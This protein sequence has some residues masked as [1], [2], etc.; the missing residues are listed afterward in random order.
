MCCHAP[1]TATSATPAPLTPSPTTSAPSTPAPTTLAPTPARTLVPTTP[2]PQP[3]ATAPEMLFS[4]VIETADGAWE[5]VYNPDGTHVYLTGKETNSIVIFEVDPSGGRLTMVGESAMDNNSAAEAGALDGPT[6]VATSPDGRCLFVAAVGSSSLTSLRIGDG[7]IGGGEGTGSL[8][9][10]ARVS[11]TALADTWDVVVSLPSGDH[12]YVS[13]PACGCIMTF[14]VDLDTCGLTYR[15]SVTS[16]LLAPAG[17]SVSP[18]GSLLYATDSAMSGGALLLFGTDPDTGELELLQAITNGVAV[19]YE[20]GG[21]VSVAVSPSGKDV[22]VASNYPGA[23][24]HLC[25]DESSGELQ[26]VEWEDNATPTGLSMDGASMVT[27]NP[28]NSRVLVASTTNNTL[29]VLDN[30]NDD[31][32][33][34]GCAI[35]ELQDTIQ[36]G[37]D[38]DITGLADARSIS[39]SPDGGTALV[40]SS[41]TG[42][43]AVFR[44]PALMETPAPTSDGESM[45][46]PSSEEWYEEHAG[47]LAMGAALTAVAAGGLVSVLIANSGCACC[48]V[49][50]AISWKKKRVD[51]PACKKQVDVK[52]KGLETRARCSCDVLRAMAEREATAD[53][54]RR[55]TKGLKPMA[56]REGCEENVLFEPDPRHV[57]M[58]PHCEIVFCAPCDIRDRKRMFRFLFENSPNGVKKEETRAAVDPSAVE[59]GMDEAGSA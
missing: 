46:L 35:L 56:M 48:I 32:S 15:S 30:V 53:G 37:D 39:V 54:Q 42:T 49:G 13:S 31:S 21:A 58:C 40:V 57:A 47:W 3:S 14:A 20:L 25:V 52:R 18:D 6:A 38:G 36:E 11:D 28:S 44:D 45:P 41:V 8:S 55:G 17:M 59:F 1:I 2:A 23:L 16:S 34:G 50:A 33:S 9:Y 24:V 10:S 22:Y 7:S 27:V 51:C 43:I 26:A 19:G 4:G 12:V 5:A 29:W